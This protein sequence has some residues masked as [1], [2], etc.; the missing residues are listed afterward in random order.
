[1]TADQDSPE[2]VVTEDPVD[3]LSGEDGEENAG[4]PI[5]EEGSWKLG[6]GLV[7][8]LEKS[9]RTSRGI[10]RWSASDH[11]PACRYELQ[12][13]S[14]AEPI[15]V[16]WD[17][18]SRSLFTA[19]LTTGKFRPVQW[20]VVRF[21]D[22]RKILVENN[23][24]GVS[25]ISDEVLKAVQALIG[26]SPDETK[27]GIVGGN[28][29]TQLEAAALTE[30]EWI[31]RGKITDRLGAPFDYVPVEAVG[32]HAPLN[33]LSA[34]HTDGRGRYELRFRL[35]LTTLASFRGIR[36]APKLAGYTDRNCAFGGEFNA[37]LFPEET[38]EKP[39]AVR[40]LVLGEA[41]MADFEM[42]RAGTIRGIVVD[43]HGKPIPKAWLGMRVPGQREGAFVAS[44]EAADDGTFLLA[45]IPTIDELEFHAVAGPGKSAMREDVLAWDAQ[46]YE[47][48]IVLGTS[49]DGTTSFD[50]DLLRD[51]HSRVSKL[52]AFLLRAASTPVP[53]PFSKGK[54]RVLRNEVG[55]ITALSLEGVRL[56]LDDAKLIASIKTL[57]RLGLSKTNVTDGD[58]ARLRD[59][60]NLSR[61]RCDYS[62]ITDAGIAHL[63]FIPKLQS[64][65][66]REVSASPESIEALREAKRGKNPRFGIG[67]RQR[68]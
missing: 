59:H 44:T 43:E 5:S 61:L 2:A 12:I 23:N 26:F 8:Q 3:L 22:P 37:L 1:M 63:H 20:Q 36:V 32:A 34:A 45:N 50:C 55:E 33:P 27:E 57:E 28:L 15:A 13:T 16:Y 64:V 24:H 17:V 47:L 38:L 39:Y 46:V 10:L 41:G 58:L 30:E 48:K 62:S 52:E 42:R 18:E 51:R 25:G 40:A 66:L 6:K 21:D 68:K 11:W 56:E 65:C 60:P 29:S 53:A 14:S 67:Y 19:R 7:F 35:P 4:K 31:V 54:T 9:G 49:A